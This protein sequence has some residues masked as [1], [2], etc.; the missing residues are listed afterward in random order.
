MHKYIIIGPQGCGK[1]TQARLLCQDFDLVHISVGDI[2]RWNMQSHTKLA[3]RIRRIMDQGLLV[4]DE[5]V[6]E[7]V[8]QRLEDHDWNYGF[9]LD[10][11]P[12]TRAQAEYLFEH[13]NL[14]AAI[15]LDIPEEVVYERVMHRAEVGDGAGFTK[16]ADD[17]PEALKVRLR[18]Y[19][20]KTAPLLNL[21]DAK[22]ML[23]RVAASGSIEEVYLAIL[24][25]LGVPQPAKG[26]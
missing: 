17:N 5:I 21:F 8:R 6:E 3:A 24:E 18:E 14:D 22:E 10:G 20:D 19:H 2:F 7:V 23:V 9:V 16:R 13:W 15:Y 26:G 4:P 1:G 12:R 25:K 11:F